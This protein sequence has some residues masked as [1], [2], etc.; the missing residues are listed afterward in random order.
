MLESM[1]FEQFDRILLSSLPVSESSRK[2]WCCPYN[3]RAGVPSAKA[4]GHHSASP[5]LNR[6]QSEVSVRSSGPTRARAGP[7]PQAVTSVVTAP[8][9]HGARSRRGRQHSQTLF[10]DSDSDATPT[11]SDGAVTAAFCHLDSSRHLRP[12]RRLDE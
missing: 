9:I 10:T 6:H 11:D 3:K 5:N 1:T 8:P 7:R 12:P 2:L 4:R